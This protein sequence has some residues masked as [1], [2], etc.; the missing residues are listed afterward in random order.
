[1]LADEVD[2]RG[3]FELLVLVD[4]FL[5]EDFLQRLEE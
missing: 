5:D 4:A 2:I 1:M 3:L